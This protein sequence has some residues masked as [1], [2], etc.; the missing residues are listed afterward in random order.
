MVIAVGRREFITLM[1][2]AALA[3]LGLSVMAGTRSAS[4]A[5]P[6]QVHVARQRVTFSSGDLAISGVHYRPQ[7]SR[8]VSRTDLE[9]RQ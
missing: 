9:S 2:G 1:G 4:Q 6:T 5:A 7:R 8:T 3:M